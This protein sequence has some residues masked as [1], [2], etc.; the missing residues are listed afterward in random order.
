MPTAI[1][2]ID[3]F[4]YCPPDSFT[5]QGITLAGMNEIISS[6]KLQHSIGRLMCSGKAKRI[7]QLSPVGNPALIPVCGFNDV[8]I[9][10]VLPGA[11]SSNAVGEI[12]PGYDKI[13]IRAEVNIPSPTIMVGMFTLLNV[14]AL[15]VKFTITNN[16]TGVSAVIGHFFINISAHSWLLA[17]LG[18][19]PIST[20]PDY[21][22]SIGSV[23]TTVTF[24][25][26]TPATILPTSANY[27]DH[28]TVKCELLTPVGVPITS[29]GL[30]TMMCVGVRSF[31][32]H[33]LKTC[34]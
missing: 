7:K 1:R 27:A 22:I 2:P 13:M 19:P 8:A 10:S 9:F 30:G 6:L 5:G 11:I 33:Q 29:L 4:P 17:F 25:A 31:S 32:I 16:E 28:C 3:G 12:L 20:D 26:D 14:Q 23:P 34:A 18:L 24:I 15:N 21:C